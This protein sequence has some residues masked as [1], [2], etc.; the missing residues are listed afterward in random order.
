MAV[1]MVNGTTYNL[2]FTGS[3]GRT[4]SCIAKC[5]AKVGTTAYQLSAKSG[6]I[7]VDQS[8]CKTATVSALTLTDP[9]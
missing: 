4:L 8:A 3:E 5:V 6:A 9:H 7:Q 1:T 2:T